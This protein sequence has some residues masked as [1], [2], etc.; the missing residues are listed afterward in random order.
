MSPSNKLDTIEAAIAAFQKGQPVVV[1]D[2]D[3]REN[4]GDL[5][6]PG[7]YATPELLAFMIRYTSGY[8]CVGMEEE[9]CD[10]LNLPLMWEKSEDPRNTAYTVSVDAAEGTTTGISAADRSLTI[11]KLA[12]ANAQPTDFRRPGH[13]LPLR[14]QSGGV[15]ERAGHTEAGVELCQLAGLPGVAALCEIVSEE[16]PTR[17][18][19]RDELRKWSHQHELR[20]IS[21]EDMTEW[22]HIHDPRR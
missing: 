17:M 9:I 11:A 2:A 22:L 8:I 12:D 7:C 13:V 3:N 18:A 4:E 15:R 6:F 14:A 1:V 10:R 19:L 16:N 20:M 21:I 5:I